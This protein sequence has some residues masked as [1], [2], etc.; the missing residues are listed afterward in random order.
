MLDYISEV[1]FKFNEWLSQG[2]AAV[3]S[4]CALTI[5]MAVR[6][7]NGVPLNSDQVLASN[8]QCTQCH[9]TGS[10]PDL[11]DKEPVILPILCSDLTLDHKVVERC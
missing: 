4:W 9:K 7:T 3:G 8:R 10:V 11:S 5:M 2:A 1:Q 6:P